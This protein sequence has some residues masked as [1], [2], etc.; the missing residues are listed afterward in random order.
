MPTTD[1][2]HMAN[3]AIAGGA[4]ST[5]NEYTN[6]LIMLVN[7]GTFNGKRV[8]SEK[9]VL[10]MEK[11]QSGNVVIGHSPYPNKPPFNPYKNDVIR[12]GIGCWRDVVNPTDQADEVSSPGLFGA[13]PW[14]APK[15][16]N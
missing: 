8:L 12:Y 13:H 14:I 4:R 3:P 15:K 6:F 16:R 9:A 10:E 7:R 2:G 5:A 1:Y 11:N